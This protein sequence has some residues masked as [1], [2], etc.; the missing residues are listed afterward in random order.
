MAQ[1]EKK[2]YLPK[3]FGNVR[4]FS[5]GSEIFNLDFIDVKELK[6][7][8]DANSK[9]GKFRITVQ[10]QRNDP[11]KASV[12][13]NTYEAKQKVEQESDTLPF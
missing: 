13:L 2:L 5:D 1:Q 10:K 12:S 6:S 3:V 8:I 4:T 11:S 7:F 9:D